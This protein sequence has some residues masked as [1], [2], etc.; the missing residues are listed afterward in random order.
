MAGATI[1]VYGIFYDQELAGR[2]VGRMR[3]AGLADADVVLRN[4]AASG[5][6]DLAHSREDNAG[7]STAV[8]TS[9]VAVGG[10]LGLIAGVG[11]MAIPGIGPILAAGPLL[12]ALAGFGVGGALGGAIDAADATGLPELGA[13]RYEGHIREGGILLSVQCHDTAA[14]S[15][16]TELLQQS[17]AQAISTIDTV[18]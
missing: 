14:V 8:V 18:R 12:G 10:T 4:P 3:D 6:K 5:S 15:R 17:G 16:A 1:A 2:C 7:S 13:R 11:A 9:S